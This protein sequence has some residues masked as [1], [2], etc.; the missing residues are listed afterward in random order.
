MRVLTVISHY[1]RLE[2]TPQGRRAYG[3]DRLPLAK[4]AA[5]NAA[6]V[7]LHRHFGPRSNPAQQAWT[8]DIVVTS[9]EGANLLEWIG[10]EPP[11]YQVE[12]YD[13]PPLMLPFETQRIMRERAGGYD[14][15]AYL[16]DDLIIDDP[17]FFEKIVWFSSTFGPKAVLTP[18]R[19]EM[20]HTGT[21]ARLAVDRQ[22]SRTA[23]APFRRSGSPATL[24]GVWNGKTQAFGLP[25]NPHSG[26]FAV[27]D[28][29]L[30]LWMASDV[31]YDRDTSWV[32]PLESAATLAP[33]KVFDL[34]RAT[35]PNPWFLAIEHFGTYYASQNEVEAGVFG[36]PPLLAWAEAAAASGAGVPAMLAEI[37]A[38]AKTNNMLAAEVVKY[39]GRLEALENSCI[40]LAATLAKTLWRKTSGPARAVRPRGQRL[41]EFG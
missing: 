39:R 26:T 21:L 36:E 38:S 25:D 22:L 19:Y 41:E 29:Q 31:F 11:A 20:A 7:G 12:Y 9:V 34:Y 35:A 8:L 3:S 17:A 14:L 5:L 4:I 16:E 10:I 23:L 37:A 30:K 33:G 15:Y 13:G 24:S 18:L 1:H 40:N 2:E 6:I 28:E 27:T 32:G